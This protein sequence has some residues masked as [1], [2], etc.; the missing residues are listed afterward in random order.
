L[1][2]CCNRLLQ[3]LHFHARVRACACGNFRKL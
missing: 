3:A 1:G 2:A